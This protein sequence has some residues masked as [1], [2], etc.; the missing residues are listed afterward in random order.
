MNEKYINIRQANNGFIV[1]YYDS[2]NSGLSG[3]INGPS[4]SYSETTTVFL[5]VEEAME[6]V[7]NILTGAKSAPIATIPE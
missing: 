4:S 6:Y 7:K 1:H 3:V 5:T 2:S